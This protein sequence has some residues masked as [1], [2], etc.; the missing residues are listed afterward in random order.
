MRFY[1]IEVEK[2][3]IPVVS[4]DG[5]KT[6]YFFEEVGITAKSVAEYIRTNSQEN[7]K[8]LADAIQKADASKALKMEEAKLAAPIPYPDQDMVC[9]GINYREHAV[10]AESFSKEAF[11]KDRPDTIYFSKRV[12]K[13]TATGTPSGVG[14]GFDPPRFLKKGDKVECYIEGI[15]QLINYVE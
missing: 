7:I 8:L 14:M 11:A 10:E 6:G 5:G 9:L 4:I 15:G 13:A 3:E 2:K 12:N 1:T